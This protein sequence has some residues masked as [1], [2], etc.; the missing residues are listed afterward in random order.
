MTR[1]P[2]H[3]LR[4]SGISSASFP[5]VESFGAEAVSACANLTNLVLS[6]SLTLVE[7]NAFRENA[8]LHTVRP[9]FP[10]ALKNVWSGAFNGCTALGGD[11]VMDGV[12]NLE[13]NAFWG[14]AFTSLSLA[15][16]T[17]IQYRALYSAPLT[18]VVFGAGALHFHGGVDR[19]FYSCAPGCRFWFPGKAPVFPPTREIGGVDVHAICDH[20]IFGNSAA[21]STKFPR[22]YGRWMKDRKGWEKILADVGYPLAEVRDELV[23]PAVEQGQRVKGAFKW[24][25]SVDKPVIETMW[26]WLIDYGPSGFTTLVVR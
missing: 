20:G 21:G 17:N 18:N 14:V 11:A 1:I 13:T 4:H 7:G 10:A 19:Q 23:V 9:F 2:Q 25:Y 22:L 12:E 16:C 15:S 5:G 26:G 3:F 24:V 8:A 6:E